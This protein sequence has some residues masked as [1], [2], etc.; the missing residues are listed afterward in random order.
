MVL[1]TQFISTDLIFNFEYRFVVM[2]SEQDAKD[3][4]LDLKM[5][6]RLFKGKALKIGLKSEHMARSFYSL[7]AVPPIPAPFPLVNPF[8][9]YLPGGIYSGYLHPPP[10]PIPTIPP[11]YNGGIYHRPYSSSHKSH[12]SVGAGSQ[13]GDEDEIGEDKQSTISSTHP[14]S[15]SSSAQNSPNKLNSGGNGSSVHTTTTNNNGNNSAP[16]P[17]STSSPRGASSVQN[18]NGGNSAATRTNHPRE[19]KVLYTPFPY[20]CFCL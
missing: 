10:H 18:N 9:S 3:T 1:E 4:I 6:R 20:L 19:K 7:N 16:A 15:Q 11:Q 17:V 13:A 14:Q 12:S 2:D 5:K 8:V